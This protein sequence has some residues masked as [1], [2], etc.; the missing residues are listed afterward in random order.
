[1]RSAEN[2]AK[3][4]QLMPAEPIRFFNRYTRAIETEVIY[5][6]KWLRLMYE[7]PV[8]GFFLWALVK[9]ALFSHYYGWQM[10]KRISA[11]KIL[12]FIINYNLNAEEFAKSPFEYRTFNEFFYRAL[13]KT[14]RPIVEGEEIVAFPADGRHLGFQNISAADGFYAKGAKF[15]LEQLLGDAELARKY[16][17]GSMVISR[18]CPVDYHRF[19]F[20]AAGIPS[21]PQLIP[22]PLFSVSPIALRRRI[23]YLAENKRVKTLLETRQFGTV[24]CMEIGATNVGTIAQTFVPGR[25]VAKGEEKGLFKFGGSCVVTLFEPGRVRLDADLV[26]SSAEYVELYAKMGDR[27]AVKA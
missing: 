23:Q 3:L 22:G 5:G 26:S 6:E 24:I 14:A 10:S 11:H 21:E 1:L 20:P 7:S 2:R 16:A 8:G 17:G 27:M 12:P 15:N 18:L 4:R 9:R 25:A 13:K 19:H